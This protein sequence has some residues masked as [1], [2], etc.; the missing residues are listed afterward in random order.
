M[1]MFGKLRHRVHVAPM[2]NRALWLCSES[3]VS[4]RGLLKRDGN[5]DDM[6]QVASAM[7]ITCMSCTMEVAFWMFL[8]AT[9]FP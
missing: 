8:P 1:G 9:L 3:A 2:D 6:Q 7:V 4:L 5:C